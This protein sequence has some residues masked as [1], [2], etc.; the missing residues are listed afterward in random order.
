[1][2]DLS[3]DVALCLA[4]VQALANRLSAAEKFA[5]DKACEDVVRICDEHD[6]EGEALCEIIR[7]LEERLE[8]GDCE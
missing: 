6:A 7:E 2:S 8:G 3:K 4:P 5:I 1:M